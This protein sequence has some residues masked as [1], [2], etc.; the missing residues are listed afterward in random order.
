M[1]FEDEI[2]SKY[3]DTGG[4]LLPL[5]TRDEARV[6]RFSLWMLGQGDGPGAEAARE[7]A[8]RL[9]RRL[10]VMFPGES[11]IFDELGKQYGDL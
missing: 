8:D 2:L 6:V 3:L 9:D 4:D 7:M 11:V 10:R 5:L 1:N